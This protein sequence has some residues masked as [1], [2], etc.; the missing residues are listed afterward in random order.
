MNQLGA[1]SSSG[2]LDPSFGNDGVVALP[3]GTPSIAVLPDNKLIAFT[4]RSLQEPLTVR[5][6]TENGTVDPSFGND[7]VIEVPVAGY[8]MMANHIE[9]LENGNYL[10]SGYEAGVAPTRRYVCRLLEDGKADASFAEAGMAT[11][12]IEEI[13]EVVD[14]VFF[15]GNLQAVS[16][17][18][19]KIY[20]SVNFYS[21][22]RGFE[23]AVFRLNEDGSRDISFNGGYVLIPLMEGSPNIFLTSLVVHGDGVLVGGGFVE[24]TGLRK[25]AFLNRYE[26]NGQADI[27]FGDRG[28]V[29]IPN[30]NDGRTSIINSIVVNTDGLIVAAGE[31]GRGAEKEGLIAVLN[32]NGSFNLIFNKGRPLYATFLI[33]LLFS[34]LVL[35][36]RKILVSGSG[37]SSGYLVAA[38]Y[39]LDGSLDPT[40]GDKGWVVFDQSGVLSAKSSLLTGNNKIVVL[41]A[42]PL[43]SY[44]VRYLG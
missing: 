2:T 13:K 4:G 34:T 38:R 25:T 43:R 24:S 26:Q 27:S 20:I 1:M 42:R 9:V 14:A 32:P 40:F 18:N 19:G 30:G 29:I 12:R 36:E 39:E 15:A 11:I 21:E 37:D 6:L 28:T 3:N 16:R 31:S 10:L 5:R 33:D 35:Q 44:A 8:H 23:A 7:G 22:K 17:L 41:A